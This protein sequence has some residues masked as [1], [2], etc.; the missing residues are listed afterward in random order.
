VRIKVFHILLAGFLLG[1]SYH[2]Q[3][4]A[5]CL[6]PQQQPIMRVDLNADQPKIDHMQPRDGLKRFQIATVSPYDSGQTVHVN[7]LMRGAISLESQTAIAWQRQDNGADNCYWFNN[8]NINIKLN[9]TIY[10]AR[11]IVKDSCLYQEVLKHEYQHY[12]VDL[13][14]AQDYQLVLQDEIQRFMQQTGVIGP[15]QSQFEAQ[16]KHEL[17]K[18]LEAIL[19]SVNDRMKFDRI[20]RQSLVDTREEYDR[21]V[22]AC[23]GDKSMM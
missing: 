8:I 11:E 16:A 15:F 4:A 13:R 7:G 10:I 14:V 17:M 19:T 20:K 6:Q 5:Q 12:A 22:R 9:P 3:A 23:P 2:S 21:I 18:R 1:M